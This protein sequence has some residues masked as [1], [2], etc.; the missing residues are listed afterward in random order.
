MDSL[1]FFGLMPAAVIDNGTRANQQ[2]VTG[3]LGTIAAEAAAAQ[4]EGPALVIV[5]TVVTLR[6]KLQWFEG[7]RSTSNLAERSISTE[8]LI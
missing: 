4:L 1:A 8:L 2:V 5:G 6:D 7:E 3:T